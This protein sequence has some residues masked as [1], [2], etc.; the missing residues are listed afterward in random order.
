MKLASVIFV[1]L[2][3]VLLVRRKTIQVDLSFPWFVAILIL[4]FAGLSPEF[5]KWTAR[6]LGIASDS[7][8]IVVL[9]LGLLLGIITT[10]SIALS[11]VRR[12]QILLIR[13]M[14]LMDLVEQR[15]QSSGR[16]SSCARSICK[17]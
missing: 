7:F 6:I 5:V 14:A 9:A 3:F 12:R 1:T 11:R 17:N 4:G 2:A 10:L 15:S 8:V 13:K 16:S